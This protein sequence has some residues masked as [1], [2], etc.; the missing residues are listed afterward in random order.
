MSRTET[1]GR[2][3]VQ[4]IAL[5]VAAV[6]VLVGIAGF[7]PG[8]TTNYD[9]L[10]VAGH[11]SQAMLLG[12]FAVSILHN[13]VHLAFGVAGFV[14]SRTANGA[15]WYLVGGGAVYLVLFVYGLI[16]DHGGDA[17]FVPVNA[18]DNWLHLL[19]GTAMILL[20]LASGGGRH[21]TV[22]GN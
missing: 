21:H 15:Y 10:M 9:A 13:V 16:V 22:R 5:V 20:G 17:N 19:L 12:L 4:T 1:A 2:H 18:A 8:L 11:E 3:A 14:L 7:V 6:F